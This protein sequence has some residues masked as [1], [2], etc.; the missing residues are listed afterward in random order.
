M[1][2]TCQGSRRGRE[3][4]VAGPAPAESQTTSSVSQSSRS[5]RQKSS[6]IAIR[7]VPLYRRRSWKRSMRSPGTSLCRCQ[8]PRKIKKNQTDARS[9]MPWLITTGGRSDDAGAGLDRTSAGAFQPQ[10]TT[11]RIGQSPNRDV[12]FARPQTTSRTSF[13]KNTG[14]SKAGET[15]RIRRADGGPANPSRAYLVH[16]KPLQGLL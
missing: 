2:A 3:G 9:E 6:R 14:N 8:I 4:A 10:P 13:I 15:R 16:G 1:E 5:P 12:L 7:R 11:R